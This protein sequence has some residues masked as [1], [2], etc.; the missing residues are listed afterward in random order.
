MN[1]GTYEDFDRYIPG[2][3]RDLVFELISPSGIMKPFWQN[4]K[5]FVFE[6]YEGVHFQKT[7]NEIVKELKTLL[8]HN[9]VI[10]VLR[11]YEN[12]RYALDSGAQ[13]VIKNTFK[14][15][16]CAWYLQHTSLKYFKVHHEILMMKPL[17]EDLN[18]WIYQM[19]YFGGAS[20]YSWQIQR[21]L[22]YND[23]F[24]DY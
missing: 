13:K 14:K 12:S 6:F 10:Q 7:L 22:T 8:I 20:K 17:D 3:S 24:S 5:V 21:N 2:R 16:D 19:D 23:K 18:D 4:L 11:G 15:Q 9:Q 1:S